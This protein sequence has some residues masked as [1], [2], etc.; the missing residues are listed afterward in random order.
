[1]AFQ[2]NPSVNGSAFTKTVHS[3]TYDFIHSSKVDH[4]GRNV[5]ITGASR[6]IGLATACSFARAGA[7]QIALT[8][9]EP[10]P[11]KVQESISEA[12][13]NCSHPPPTLLTYHLDVNDIASITS[14]VE[15]ITKT[16]GK[17]DILVNN[18]G[19]MPSPS[20]IAESDDETYWRTFEINIR[21]TYRMTKALLP[22]L[23]STSDGLKTIVN[24]S[25]V[26][27]HNLRPD[28]S[29]YG[30]TKFAVLR[31]TEFLCQENEENGL[32]AFCVHPGAIMTKLAE[33]MPKETHAGLSDKPA[34]AGDTITFLAE[35]RRQWLNARYVSAQWDMEEFLGKKDDIV[36][37]DK[38]KMRMVW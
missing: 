18:A 1:M 17:L 19:Y 22:L 20:P 33:A 23:L 10:F 28:S 9:I 11:T 31:F 2:P 27:A 25:S 32:V 13:K 26:A 35:G 4:V 29:A 6:G 38:L 30:M 12:A 24:L 16:F 7:S 34:L 21:G 14:A 3:D 8:S 5:L 37:G 36:A 15:D